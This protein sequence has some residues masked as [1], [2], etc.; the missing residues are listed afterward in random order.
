M[1][2]N[3]RIAAYVATWSALRMEPWHL[4]IR[5]ARPR[6]GYGALHMDGILAWCVVQQAIHGAT[7][8]DSAEPYDVPIPL[9][10]LWRDPTGL[11]LW[12]VTDLAPDGPNATAR[13]TWTRKQAPARLRQLTAAGEPSVP[14]ATKGPY[15]DMQIPLPT[16]VTAAYTCDLIGDG[17]MV[18]ELLCMASHIG[19]KR[20]QGHGDILDWRLDTIETFVLVDTD[21]AMRRTIP[22]AALG[23]EDG[24]WLAWTP[25]YWHPGCHEACVPAGMGGVDVARL[26]AWSPH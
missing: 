2:S 26:A 7:L 13:S 21:G 5:M 9:A 12:A 20:G 15:K 10:V 17:A 4:T 23:R 6:A 16:D 1:R 18:G 14:F 25:P 24:Q 22:P 19:K 8:T 11:P 3:P